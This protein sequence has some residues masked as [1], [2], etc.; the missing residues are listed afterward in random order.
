MDLRGFRTLGLAAL[1]AL[2]SA[3]ALAEDSL[4]SAIYVRTDGDDTLVVSPRATARKQ[5]VDDTAVEVT[6]AAD[7]WTSASVDIRA[8]ASLPV[9]E[10]R[11]ELEATITHQLT[12]LTFSGTY[13]YSV[14]NDYTSHGGF[15]S[16][17]YDFAD[18]NATLALH[19]F[20]LFDTV[21]RAGLPRF[22]QR[23]DTVGARLSFTQ[24]IDTRMLAQLTYELAHMDGYQ[25]SPYRKIG[26]DGTGFGCR[27]AVLCVDEHD[28]DARTRHAFALVVRRAL[29]D[30]FSL[31]ASYRFILDDWGLTSQTAS[32]DV[33]LT[34]GAASLLSLRYRFYTQTGVRF[35]SRVYSSSLPAGAYM[36]RDREQSPMHDQRLGLDWEQKAN[37]AKDLDLAITTSVAG[38]LFEYENFVG[39]TRVYALE[40]T[41]AVALVR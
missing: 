11:D 22:A 21:G 24:V 14:E 31:G 30:A 8:S 1:F 23:L 34:L 33:G 13:R 32:L 9:T 38:T 7:V 20:G 27:M 36:T 6:Y 4:S 18:N 40:L 3:H 39:L 12:D 16:G 28:P 26:L 17:A 19:A 2:L 25:A 37:I 29:S 35:Y 41:L 15:V 10:Q 5:I